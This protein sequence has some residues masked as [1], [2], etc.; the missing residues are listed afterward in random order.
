MGIRCRECGRVQPMPTYDVR[1][2]NYTRA[3][4]VA[5]IL[6][7][8]GAP[9]WLLLDQALL[10]FGAYGSVSGMLAIPF[11]YVSGDLISRAANRKR[12]IILALI[13]CFAL[14]LT[15]LVSRLFSPFFF[16][17]WD[18]LFLAIGLALAWQRLK[19]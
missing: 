4:G 10:V 15:F 5:M 17:V 11:G 13:G 8:F 9:L 19:R 14:I 18:V 7:I 1:P 12:S 3:I 2:T 6:L 16:G